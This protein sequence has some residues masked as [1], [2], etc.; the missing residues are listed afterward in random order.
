MF[1]IDY[2][3]SAEEFKAKA[4]CVVDAVTRLLW[5]RASHFPT[6]GQMTLICNPCAV[7][8]LESWNQGDC[9]QQGEKQTLT[10]GRCCAAS[11]DERSGHLS[12][13]LCLITQSLFV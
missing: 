8:P 10:V 4:G 7:C 2:F 1:P 3:G 5:I 12:S 6:A 13:S 9:P 11:E